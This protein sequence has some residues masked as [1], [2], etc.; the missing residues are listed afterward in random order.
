MI[1][2]D[3]KVLAILMQEWFKVIVETH[4]SVTSPLDCQCT[5][6]SGLLSSASCYGGEL[7]PLNP[8]VERSPLVGCPRLLVQYIRD[9]L[10]YL[11]AVSSVRNQRTRTAVVA[12]DPPKKGKRACASKLLVLAFIVIIII[13]GTTAL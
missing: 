2:K 5:L 7:S 3:I 8:Q 6:K 11:E 13:S 9:L 10:P 12:R 4:S 1:S